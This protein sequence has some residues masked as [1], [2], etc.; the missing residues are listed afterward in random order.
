MGS[1]GSLIYSPENLPENVIAK[2]E[3]HMPRIE[4]PDGVGR[5]EEF[6]VEVSVGPHSNTVEHSIRRIEVYF[7]EEGRPFNPILLASVVLTPKYSVPKIVFRL[8]L[9]K[10]GTIYAIAYC[11]LH[12]VWE[13]R[14]E[15]RVG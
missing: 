1:F 2:R 8:R 6:T 13:S 4:A 12:G 10:S 14:E 7:Y 11:N 9:E 3:S 5:G 15:I